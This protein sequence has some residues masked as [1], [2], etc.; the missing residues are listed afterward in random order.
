MSIADA[1]IVA[2]KASNDWSQGQLDCRLNGTHDWNNRRTVIVRHSGGVMEV[3]QEC[4]RR[5]GV[6]RRADWDSRTGHL[7]T[8][9]RLNYKSNAA[10][11]Y[12][13]KDPES[14]RSMGRIDAD[15]RAVIRLVA[16]S[17]ARVIEVDDSA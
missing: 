11:R 13:M 7:L 4:G 2:A 8:R 16:W 17:G 12:L 14:G 1:Q 5:C 6:S 3:Q 9:W 10:Q 15:G